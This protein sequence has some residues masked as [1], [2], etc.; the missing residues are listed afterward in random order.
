[1]MI[2]FSCQS[3]LPSSDLTTSTFF[4]SFPLKPEDFTFPSNTEYNNLHFSG[5]KGLKTL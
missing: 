2:L 4:P 1:M 3:Q 5:I